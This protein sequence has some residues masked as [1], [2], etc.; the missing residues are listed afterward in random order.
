MVDDAP[1]KD[2]EDAPASRFTSDYTT[3]SFDDCT[4]TRRASEGIGIDYRCPGR[5]GIPLLL[6]D[7][8][9]RYDVDAGIRNDQFQSIGAFNS[10]G[11][12]IEWRLDQGAPVAVIFR[13]YDATQEQRGRSVLAVEKIGTA[14]APG[15]RIAQ[16]AGDTDDANMRA[17]QI[18][19]R[20]AAGFACASDKMEVVGNAL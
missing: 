16:V 11:T 19:D 5:G 1:P 6:H 3:L 9:G 2:A 13:L 12:T 14:G 20:Q 18:A 4:I 7:G 15:C 17:R 10:I 8:D